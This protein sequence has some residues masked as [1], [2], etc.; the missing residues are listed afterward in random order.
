MF[1]RPGPNV[2][3]PEQSPGEVIFSLS[4]RKDDLNKML[5]TPKKTSFINICVALSLFVNFFCRQ[6]LLRHIIN[7]KSLSIFPTRLGVSKINLRTQSVGV[8]CRTQIDCV[9]V[10]NCVVCDC[11]AIKKSKQILSASQH[12]PFSIHRRLEDTLSHHMLSKIT[13]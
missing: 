12:S 6:P 9:C 4:S 7:L 10:F 2:S 3:P 5:A 1:F 8:W 11:G 13:E